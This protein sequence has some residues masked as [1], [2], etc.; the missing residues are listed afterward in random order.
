MMPPGHKLAA[1]TAYSKPTAMSSCLNIA[2]FKNLQIFKCYVLASNL[3]MH[4]FT[5]FVTCLLSFE[6]IH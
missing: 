1:N 5:M 2:E 3:F 4:I 6:R